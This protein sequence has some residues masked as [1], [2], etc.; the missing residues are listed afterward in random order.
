MTDASL[1]QLARVETLSE[2]RVDG[3]HGLTDLAM[4]DI[5][6]RSRNTLTVLN[7]S[8]CPLLT[9]EGI[10]CVLEQQGVSGQKRC[11]S[12]E[13]RELTLGPSRGITDSACTFISAGATCLTHLSLRDCPLMLDEG[14]QTLASMPFLSALDLCGCPRVGDRGIASFFTSYDGASPKVQ[15]NLTELHISGCDVGTAGFRR[16]RKGAPALVSLS[17]AAMSSSAAWARKSCC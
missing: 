16:I 12:P 8:G 2:L 6:T 14:L 17:A 13:L 1:R 10:R 11:G 7:L 4:F 9:D 3:C 15:T 5:L